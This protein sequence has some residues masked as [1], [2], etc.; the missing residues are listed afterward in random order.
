MNNLYWFK[1]HILPSL[2]EKNAP[3]LVYTPSVRGEDQFR[4]M[5]AQFVRLATDATHWAYLEPPG[6]D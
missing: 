5:S 1:M 4:I 2:S 3:V 6:E